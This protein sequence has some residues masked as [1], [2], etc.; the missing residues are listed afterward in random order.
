[1]HLPGEAQAFL[2]LRFDDV[3]HHRLW[4]SR[5]FEADGFGDV[6]FLWSGV[7]QDGLVEFRQAGEVLLIALQFFQLPPHCEEPPLVLDQ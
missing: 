4:G 2:F 6:E 1:M 5:F 7:F 3:D